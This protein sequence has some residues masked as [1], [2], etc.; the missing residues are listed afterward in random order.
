MTTPDTTLRLP[1]HEIVG[2]LRLEAKRIARDEVP[3]SVRR[4]RI[5]A[6]EDGAAVIERVAEMVGAFRTGPDGLA[7]MPASA[8][9]ILC[10]LAREGGVRPP[11]LTVLEG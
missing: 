9:G 6:L 7:L 4:R 5:S 1:L 10:D 8:A 3:G 11:R 2:A